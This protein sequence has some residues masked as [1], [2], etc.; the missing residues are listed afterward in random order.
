MGETA[1]AQLTDLCPD[2]LGKHQVA[3]ESTE[4]TF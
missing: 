1:E 4:N 2:S 3:F